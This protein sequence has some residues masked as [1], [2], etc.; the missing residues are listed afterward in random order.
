MRRSLGKSPSF[1]RASTIGIHDVL[2]IT[3]AH[4][5]L[6]FHTAFYD[7]LDA[8]IITMLVVAE[9]PG[10]VRICRI[11]WYLRFFMCSENVVGQGVEPGFR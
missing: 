3:V 5:D 7:V 2:T 1:S 10:P 6:R 8:S 9:T 11:P 4:L